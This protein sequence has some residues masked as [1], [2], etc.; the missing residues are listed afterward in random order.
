MRPGAAAATFILKSTP[1]RVTWFSPTGPGIDMRAAL[2]RQ[3]F[4][5]GRHTFIARRKSTVFWSGGSLRGPTV[6][7]VILE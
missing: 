2:R 3:V 7:F 1:D 4:F 5:K 6:L